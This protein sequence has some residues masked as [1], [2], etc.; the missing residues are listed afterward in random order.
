MH[1][2]SQVFFSVAQ[3][4]PSLIIAGTW[5]SLNGP[6]GLV[7]SGYPIELAKLGCAAMQDRF[8]KGVLTAPS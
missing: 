2:S 1:L 3:V 5:I 6:V 8:T 7:L 4:I